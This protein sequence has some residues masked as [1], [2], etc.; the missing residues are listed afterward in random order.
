MLRR[1]LLVSAL[2]LGS[3]VGTANADTLNFTVS[4][5]HG[6]GPFGTVTTT[7]LG[8]NSVQVTIDMGANFIIEGGGGSHYSLTFSTSLPGTITGLTAGFT[9]L[10]TLNVQCVGE[11]IRWALVPSAAVDRLLRICDPDSALPVCSD[12]D[13]ALTT[14]HSDPP[15]L[16]QLVPESS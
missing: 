6:T 12:V 13:D 16:L 5:G 11:E 7:D 2:S 4:D 3:L 8:G 14:V 9:A 15:R 10:H 1:L